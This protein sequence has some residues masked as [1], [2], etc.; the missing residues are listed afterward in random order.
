VG[1]RHEANGVLEGVSRWATQTRHGLSNQVYSVE[2]AD[3]VSQSAP[4]ATQSI[5]QERDFFEAIAHSSGR[6]EYALKFLGDVSP[7]VN[8]FGRMMSYSES[9]ESF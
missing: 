6:L 8:S 7:S 2:G 5:H 3:A 1:V 9:A 4:P